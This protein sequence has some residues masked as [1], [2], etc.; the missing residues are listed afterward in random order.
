[1]RFSVLLPGSARIP[2]VA[3]WVPGLTPADYQRFIGTVDELG[4]HAIEVPEHLAL[5]VHEVPRLGPYWLDALTAMAFIA[6]ASRRVRVDASVLVLPYHHPV[7]LAKALAT[8]DVL[9]GG[10]VNFSL[11]VGHAE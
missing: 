1:M 7:K 4:Y 9:S 5:P 8:L 3:D 2:P 10:R 6:G 11:G